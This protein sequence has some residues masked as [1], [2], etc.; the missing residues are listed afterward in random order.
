[1][2][3][4]EYLGE[5]RLIYSSVVFMCYE[6]QILKYFSPKAHTNIRQL[7]NWIKTYLITS[8]YQCFIFLIN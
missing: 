8:D 7:I 3:G 5:I 6:M 2:A 1:M 4:G